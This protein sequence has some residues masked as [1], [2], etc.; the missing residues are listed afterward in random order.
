MKFLIGITPC[1]TILYLSQCWGGRVSD[2]NI[3]QASNFFSLLEPGDD[4]LADRKF[5]LADDLTIHGVRLEIPAFTRGKKQLLQEDVEKLKQLS[6]VRIHME[7]VIGLLKNQY[8]ILKGTMPVS[9]LIKHKRDTDVANI[10]KLLVV[11]S[12]LTNLGETVVVGCI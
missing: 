7:R 6:T 11:C 12:A 1:G 3:M 2:K 4:V 10:D 9:S 5:T 8:T